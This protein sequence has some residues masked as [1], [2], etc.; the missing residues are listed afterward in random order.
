MI[1]YNKAYNLLSKLWKTANDSTKQ[2]LVE[3]M[4]SYLAKEEKNQEKEYAILDFMGRWV[5]GSSQ[6]ID[7]S[8]LKCDRGFSH[9]NVNK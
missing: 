8:G 4:F 7:H 1:E 9:Y 6:S 5:Y 2:G 3:S